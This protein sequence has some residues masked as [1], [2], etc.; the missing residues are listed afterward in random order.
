MGREAE[1]SVTT[2]GGKVSAGGSLCFV[3]TLGVEETLG[4][5]PRGRGRRGESPREGSWGFKGVVEL[6]NVPLV[7]EL[8]G[9]KPEGRPPKRF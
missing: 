5:V 3:V 7:P 9:T 6:G 1:G 4:P 2:G 8:G